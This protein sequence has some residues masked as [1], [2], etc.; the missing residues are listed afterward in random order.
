[1]VAF[2]VKIDAVGF[3][4]IY[5]PLVMFGGYEPIRINLGQ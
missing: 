4:V 2:E 5:E 1:L 3:T